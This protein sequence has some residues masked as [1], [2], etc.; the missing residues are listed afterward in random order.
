LKYK[1][2]LVQCKFY[3]IIV[4]R[5]IIVQIQNLID[6]FNRVLATKE[7]CIVNI[8]DGKLVW[9]NLTANRC[10]KD[11][12]DYKRKFGIINLILKMY[13]Q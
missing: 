2:V 13:N 3:D 5:V 10:N 9:L 6:E 1:G 8:V 4:K 12:D 11:Y 7:V